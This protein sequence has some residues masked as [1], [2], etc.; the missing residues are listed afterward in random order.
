MPGHHFGRVTPDLILE[1][2]KL[3]FNPSLRKT[4][5]GLPAAANQNDE[6]Y[7]KGKVFKM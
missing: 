7:E 3:K 5:I 4:R 2:G 1:V 6:Y